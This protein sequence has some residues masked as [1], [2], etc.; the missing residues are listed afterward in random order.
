MERPDANSQTTGGTSD[1]KDL[2][3]QQ[4]QRVAG[5]AQQ[6]AGAVADTAKHETAKVVDDAKHHVQDLTQDAKHQLHQQARSQTE[7]LGGVVS[8][9]GERVQALAD[10][11]PEEAGPIGD[12]ASSIA[13]QVQHLAG[14]VD[15]LGF[16]GV[17]DEVQRFARR[18][19][20]A[21]LAGAAVAG[22]AAA[23]LAS[24]ARSAEQSSGGD[25]RSSTGNDEIDLR[26]GAVGGP[27]SGRAIPGTTPLPGAEVRGD[28][29]TPPPVTPSPS[30]QPDPL[31]TGRVQP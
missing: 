29:P 6:Q 30:S 17:M 23:R 11:K 14:E 27:P 8:T 1:N 7:Q 16:D 9:L 10:G 31:A 13:G 22:F 28:R 25:G 2:A 5:E 18:R 4:G 20:G 15:R 26:T 24:G 3:K 12:Y 21:F 19:P